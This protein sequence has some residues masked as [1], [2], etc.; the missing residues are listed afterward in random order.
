MHSTTSS[1]A[2]HRPLF[3]VD[4]TAWCVALPVSVVWTSRCWACVTVCSGYR[5]WEWAV[6]TV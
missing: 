5:R 4:F 3:T 2:G 1:T 6:L